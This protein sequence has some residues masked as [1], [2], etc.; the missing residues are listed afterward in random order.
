[1]RAALVFL[2]LALP[3]VGYAE[4]KREREIACLALN[5]YH[6][7]RSEGWEG[8]RAVGWVT[9]NRVIN[10]RFPNTIC[11]V[12]KQGQ[13]RGKHPIRHK[14]QFSWWCDGKKD[15]PTEKATFYKSWAKAIRVLREFRDANDPTDGALFYH[16]DYVSPYWASRK[17]LVTRIGS[18]LFYR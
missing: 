5:M 2:L 9:L 12:V 10:P 16:A 14:C 3:A 15:Y 4:T 8:Q 6:E 13:Y 18:H 11:E 17:T 1:M 7:A